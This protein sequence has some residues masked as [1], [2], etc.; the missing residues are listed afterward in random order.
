[1][2]VENYNKITQKRYM[3]NKILIA[4]KLKLNCKEIEL[5]DGFCNQYSY[6]YWSTQSPSGD[7]TC[8]GLQFWNFGL[9][10]IKNFTVFGWTFWETYQW[11]RI[12]GWYSRHWSNKSSTGDANKSQDKIYHLKWSVKTIKS[13]LLTYGNSSSVF[14]RSWRYFLGFRYKWCFISAKWIFKQSFE[15]L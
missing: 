4:L 15:G 8:I 5:Q 9:F 12:H 2:T 10:Y 13:L 1:M 6:W 14:I 11:N 7:R 3:E